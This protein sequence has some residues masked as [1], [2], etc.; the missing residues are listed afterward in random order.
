MRNNSMLLIALSI[1]AVIKEVSSFT[2]ISHS[3]CGYTITQH[4]QQQQIISR[5]VFFAT[6]RS[7]NNKNN[8]I[9]SNNI[10][11]RNMSSSAVLESPNA[12]NNRNRRS[13]SF[14]DRMR[15][16]VQRPAKKPAVK[17]T[18]TTG[19][20]LLKPENMHVATTL[21]DYKLLVGDEKNTIVIVRFFATWCK[22]CQAIGPSFYRLARQHPN[23]KFV[24]V[25]VTDTNVELHQGLNVP[26]LPFAHIYHP[27]GGLVEEMK[28]SKKFF[29]SF[30]DV[31]QSYV[32][33]CCDVIDDDVLQ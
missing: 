17:I 9:N 22:A 14:S 23:I 1:L 27:T 15:N 28:I 6:R 5:N 12:N 11:R 16:L 2:T 30:E 7:S 13:S 32:D 3:N 29:R 24:E 10:T 4:R 21:D 26:S 8:N 20:K 18:N 25:P 31:V 33:G 19:R